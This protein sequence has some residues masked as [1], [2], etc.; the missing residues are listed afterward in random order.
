MRFGKILILVMAGA[1]GCAVDRGIVHDYGLYDTGEVQAIAEFEYR[2]DWRSG[3]K[4]EYF[5]NGHLKRSE[6]SRHG[7]P[8]MVVNFHEN[9]QLKSEERFKGDEIVFGAYYAVDGTLT[10]EI[11]E[12]VHGLAK[13]NR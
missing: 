11:G 8:L 9:G 2:G 6:W 12:K 4:N 5:K 10:R 3:L 13:G 1:T 7:K